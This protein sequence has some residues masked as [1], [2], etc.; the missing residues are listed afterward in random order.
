MAEDACGLKAERQREAWTPT[1]DLSAP[2][3]PSQDLENSFPRWQDPAL[4]RTMYA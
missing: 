2:R 3:V 1:E 4:K